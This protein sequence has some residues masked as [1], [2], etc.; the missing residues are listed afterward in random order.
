M[1]KSKRHSGSFPRPV[2]FVL[3]FYGYRRAT[4]RCRV[5]EVGKSSLWGCGEGPPG[6]RFGRPSTHSLVPGNAVSQ[7]A[8]L[9]MSGPE[10]APLTRG[11]D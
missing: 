2:S 11:Q 1:K 8:P 7:R 3:V 5:P 9:H 4:R 10:N 6:G